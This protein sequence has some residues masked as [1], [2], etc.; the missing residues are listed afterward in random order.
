[1]GI[2]ISFPWP[3]RVGSRAWAA[4]L[5]IATLVW[6]ADAVPGTPGVAAADS[7]TARTPIVGVTKDGWPPFDYLSDGK[8]DGLSGAF[9]SK[10]LGIGANGFQTRIFANAGDL[11]LAA[12][13]GEVDIVP[14][15]ARTP[16]R[17]ACL[18]FSDPYYD[19]SGVVVT[20]PDRTAF[21]SPAL[22]PSATYAVEEGFFM[23]RQLR[24]RYP[25]ARFLY[26][27]NTHEAL[28]AVAAG[29]ADAYFGLLPSV[30]YE[31]RDPELRNLVI[32]E[33]HTEPSGDLRF[34]FPLDHAALRD[35]VNHGLERINPDERTQLLARWISGDVTPPPESST[36]TLSPDEQKFLAG[37]PPLKATLVTRWAPYSYL[38]SAGQPS[39]MLPEYLA[40]IAK[41]LNIRIV[42][43]SSPRGSPNEEGSMLAAGTTDLV[44]YVWP[45]PNRERLP[46]ATVP[47]MTYPVAIVGRRTAP[48]VSSL[49]QLDGLRVAVGERSGNA[50]W[51]HTEAP[52]A[53]TIEVRSPTDGLQ[54]VRE[55]NADVV[56]GNL[57]AL[58]QLLQ[59]DDAE[60]FKVLGWT[61][62]RQAIGFQFRAGLE[63][64]VAI[65]NRVLTTMPEAQR[66]ALQNRYL[67][68]RYELGLSWQDAIRRSLPILLIVLAAIVALAFGYARLRTEVRQRKRTEADLTTQLKFR[69]TLLDLV[70]LPIG[71]RD[72]QG[73]YIDVN[74]GAAAAIGLPR[75]EIIGLTIPECIR[76][77]KLTGSLTHAI[78][79][80]VGE[81]KTFDGVFVRFVNLDGEQRHG[82]YWSRQFFDEG[83]KQLGSVGVVVDVTPVVN[84]ERKIRETEAL[85]QDITR[86]LPAAVFQLRRDPNN[87]L[88]Y[89][90][91]GGNEELL[92][93]LP[94]F[95]P[96][97]KDLRHK[98]AVA[99]DQIRYLREAFEES[100]RTMRP[101]FADVQALDGNAVRWL[102][103]SA[104]PRRSEDGALL[105]DGYWNDT[106]REHQRAEEL[107]EARDA[108]EHASVVK[109]QFLAMMSHEIRTPMS[110]VLGLVEI[111]AQGDLRGD[112]APIVGMI[113]DSA[114]ALLQI[115]DDI[116]DYSKIQA[117][118]LAIE[119][120][121]F[122]LRAVCDL[123][124]G[125]LSARAHEKGL[126]MRCRI[127]RN[128]AARHRGDSVRIRQVLFNL[129]GNSTKFT[130]NGTISLNVDIESD[131]GSAQVLRLAV[132]DTGIG[133]ETEKIPMLFSPFVQA[134]SSTS[135]RF[136]G[137]GLGLAISN[138]LIKLMGGKI[139]IASEPGKGTRVTVCLPLPVEKRKQDDEAQLRQLRAA[140]LVS[141]R[142]L[143]EALREGLGALGVH[144]AIA[145]RDEMNTLPGEESSGTP[146]VV[147]LDA[148]VPPPKGLGERLTAIHV[149]ERPKA[150]GYRLTDDDI[151]LSVN[152]LSFRGL[153]AVCHA[154][155]GE[156][157]NAHAQANADDTS[158]PVVRT[159]DEAL[160]DGALIL[161]AED[162][163]V[164]RHLIQMQLQL[165]GCASDAVEDG[166]QALKLYETTHYAILITD[167]HMPN[168]NGYALA[169]EIRERE[170]G[171]RALA[172]ASERLPIIG[173]TAS[174]QPD[175]RERCLGAGMD[176]WLRKPAQIEVLRA[177]LARWA[178][179]CLPQTAAPSQEGTQS[180]STGSD[181]AHSPEAGDSGDVPLPPLDWQAICGQQ[182]H[183]GRDE[184]LIKIGAE[185]LRDDVKKL[186]EL[187]EAPDEGVLREWIHRVS[188]TA[189]LLRYTPLADALADFRASVLG[190][191][192]I[193]LE[194]AARKV[195]ARLLRIAGHIATQ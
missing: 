12:C 158:L 183:A 107:E 37:L 67:T 159:R 61:G 31:M 97:S 28:Q 153:R 177:C 137:T 41:R 18:T 179:A 124:M 169:G 143:A 54:L 144:A 117:N 36:F 139:D 2:G 76:R 40:Y 81:N 140:I 126:T 99:P 21:A 42:Q 129:L 157:V 47:I 86:N 101:L 34:A 58:D 168:I 78:E 98:L 70:P 132:A 88:A 112:Q 74:A 3:R 72:A 1:M 63:P 178:P 166:A 125:M 59:G 26:T 53:K 57:A 122:D 115:L 119:S 6:P 184:T 186:A 45:V 20:R 116:L 152:P 93:E 114:G 185:S 7:A 109:D 164:N 68:T 161:V 182:S 194:T 52:N 193:P 33:A 113:H 181:P 110:G 16:Q 29:R 121:P 192:A 71:V 4:G 120:E 94:Q 14:D 175:E 30:E 176:D 9:L 84:A 5:V 90:Y 138:Q 174:V 43:T 103:I 73:R 46:R 105:W 77:S 35:R 118:K 180:G 85:L 141:N 11:V 89:Q 55:G 133:I 80:L 190:Q 96:P 130:A 22:A 39:G 160:R 128:V 23:G 145:S 25:D 49:S 136:G 65:V 171:Q 104:V 149:T 195:T 148:E 95:G 156:R 51:V 167:C 147:F 69:E 146:N 135:R 91:V 188:G 83:G 173:V 131:T 87:R 44:V 106:T 187:L 142:N 172:S 24:E 13:R 15:L 27:P 170:R 19:G 102:Q 38:D 66:A 191:S 32:S 92:P 154:A 48:V 100:G 165:L 151:R 17:E 50:A 56:I 189:M 75:S 79:A 150:A 111:L 60:D 127:D 123:V 162:N 155:L 134:D 163:P 62:Y 8:L 108:A 64:L 10:A 82:L